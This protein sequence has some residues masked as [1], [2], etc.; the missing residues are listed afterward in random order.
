MC[1]TCGW[2]HG[3]QG[4]VA[5]WRTSSGSTTLSWT[6][7]VLL[8]PSAGWVPELWRDEREVSYWAAHGGE[9]QCGD[10][11]AARP[12]GRVQCCGLET[13]PARREHHCR[14][15]PFSGR[16]GLATWAVLF[17]K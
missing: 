17:W 4:C 7:L 6:V 14:Q 10:G 11:H 3:T 15:S 2:S 13:K 5:S 1:R 16:C 8:M 9:A 12:L